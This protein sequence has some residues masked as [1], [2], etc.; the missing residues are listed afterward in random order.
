MDTLPA[1]SLISHFAC[2][3]FVLNSILQVEEVRVPLPALTEEDYEEYKRLIRQRKTLF[4]SLCLDLVKNNFR[5]PQKT[6]IP[7]PSFL[8]SP[9]A[10]ERTIL[11]EH[12]LSNIQIKGHDMATL[13]PSTWLNDEIINVCMSMLQERDSRHRKEKNGSTTCHFFNSFFL[14]KLYKDSGKYNYNDVRRWTLPVRLKNAGQPF[15]SILDC[16]KIIMPANQGNMHWVCAVIDI[17]NQ[18]FIMYDSLGVSFSFRALF[19]LEIEN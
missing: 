14:N 2:W 8:F 17:K 3:F 10:A 16:D 6:K 15:T 5:R 11:A 4:F 18:K 12:T 9:C 7:F 19:Y 1:A 13:A